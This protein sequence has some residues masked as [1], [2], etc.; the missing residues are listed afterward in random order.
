MPRRSAL[1]AVSVLALSCAPAAVPVPTSP[2][3]PSAT[4]VN[5][6]AAQPTVLWTSP[7]A[8]GLAPSPSPSPPEAAVPAATLGPTAAPPPAPRPTSSP[9]PFRWTGYSVNGSAIYVP[10][11]WTVVDP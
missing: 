10:A 7:P 3:R 6:P 2:P 4:F 11:A 5:A 9:D 1:V 8:P